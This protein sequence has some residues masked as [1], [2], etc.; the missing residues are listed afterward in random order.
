VNRSYPQDFTSLFTSFYSQLFLNIQCEFLPV[1]T[2]LQI[3][4]VREKGK[5][6]VNLACNRAHAS[7]RDHISTG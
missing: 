3:L 4:L 2:E 5:T 6:E 1:E 7:L